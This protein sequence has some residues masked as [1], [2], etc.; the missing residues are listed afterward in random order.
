[1]SALEEQEQALADQIS[2]VEEPLQAIEKLHAQEL[3]LCKTQTWLKAKG[4]T[5]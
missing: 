3:E 1:V 5:P 2:A 4:V